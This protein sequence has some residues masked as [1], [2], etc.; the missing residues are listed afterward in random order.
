MET[1]IT[2]EQARARRKH[3]GRQSSDPFYTVSYASKATMQDKDAECLPVPDAPKDP[4]EKTPTK[5]L[6][7]V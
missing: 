5:E 6:T 2:K 7:A 3:F 1:S 4:V